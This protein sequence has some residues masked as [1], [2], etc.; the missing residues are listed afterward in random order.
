M[1][2]RLVKLKGKL[3]LYCMNGSITVASREVLVK[4]LTH[5]D[6]PSTFRGQDGIWNATT[7]DIEAASGQT[8]AYVNDEKNLVICNAK[9]FQDIIAEEETKYLSA[10]E[11]AKKYDK[12]CA[13]IKR[14][15]LEGRFDGAYKSSMGWLIPENAPYPKRGSK[16]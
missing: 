16:S 3:L 7:Q 2:L 13:I 11:Y 15:C 12:S 1:K 4:L 10:N 9:V 5:F 6:A 8:M 14:Y